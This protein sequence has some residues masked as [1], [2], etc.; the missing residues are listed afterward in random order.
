[1]VVVLAIGENV[2]V[3]AR[4]SDNYQTLAEE[5]ERYEEPMDPMRRECP[6]LSF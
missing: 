4:A 2:S 3:L 5:R 6:R 1:M